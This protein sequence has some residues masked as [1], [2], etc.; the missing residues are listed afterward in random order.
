MNNIPT[1]TF[2]NSG[3]EILWDSP[4]AHRAQLRGR[5][6]CFILNELSSSTCSLVGQHIKELTPRSICDMFSKTMISEH[7]IDIES[8]NTDETIGISNDSALLV[9]EVQPLVSNFIITFSN[10]IYN[11]SSV[12]T[13][14]N[15]SAQ[16]PLEFIEFPL[17]FE[18]KA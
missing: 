18:K 12:S 11:F 7:S 5:S 17:R 6:K 1:N 16:S 13:S 14:L 4:V 3:G 8:F 9:K 10:L 2:M 15:L